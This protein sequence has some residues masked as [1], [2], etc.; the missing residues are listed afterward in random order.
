MLLAAQRP[1][2]C[3]TYHGGRYGKQQNDGIY[4]NGKNYRKHGG[5][6]RADDIRQRIRRLRK[7]T[8]AARD[9]SAVECVHLGRFVCRQVGVQRPLMQH[10]AEPDRAAQVEHAL[11]AAHVQHSDRIR[12]DCN[13]RRKQQ[14]REYPAHGA[15]LTQCVH[16]EAEHVCAR[17][18]F[19]RLPEQGDD[20][21]KYHL[22]P[23]KLPCHAQQHPQGAV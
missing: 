21:G 18:K 13:E 17:E 8:D 12:G 19:R 16:R 7:R 20:E 1:R 22:P 15:L 5:V 23:I 3:Q 6:D 2:S 10:P 14:K 4:P 11:Y 9:R